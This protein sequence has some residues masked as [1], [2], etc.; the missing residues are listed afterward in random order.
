[1]RSLS[2]QKPRGPLPGNAARGKQLVAEKG[3]LACHLIRGEGG[4]R[5]PDLSAIGSQRSPENLR[6]SLTDPS[7]TIAP[8]YRVVRVSTR[9]DRTSTGFLL[10]QDTYTVQ[11]QD[12][13]KGLTSIS[14][15][16]IKELNM[17]NASLMPSFKSLTGTEL[18]DIVNYLSSLIGDKGA[19]E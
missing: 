13:S 15:S 6:A 19:S 11:L 9:D 10:N 16:A 1:V 14:R 18:D 3:C 12:F 5:G 8:R 7:A 4:D 17:D 2:Q